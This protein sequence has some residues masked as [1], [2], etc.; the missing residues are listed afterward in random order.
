MRE[1][2]GSDDLRSNWRCIARPHTHSTLLS[3]RWQI[4]LGT[5]RHEHRACNEIELR[6]NILMNDAVAHPEARE[7][8]P[9]ND[10]GEKRWFERMNTEMDG[11]DSCN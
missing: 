6:V 9:R 10:V 2:R 11:V 5:I 7:A 4:Y 8:T 1:W 3:L